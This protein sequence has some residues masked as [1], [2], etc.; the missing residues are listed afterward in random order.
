MS[1]FISR[2]DNDLQVICIHDTWTLKDVNLFSFLDEK[3]DGSQASRINSVFFGQRYFQ[4]ASKLKLESTYYKTVCH[5][6]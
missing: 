4:L 5:L 3:K 2:Y 6:C 1:Y